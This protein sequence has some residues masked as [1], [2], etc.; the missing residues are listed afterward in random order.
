VTGYPAGHRVA[1]V[2]TKPAPVRHRPLRRLGAAGAGLLLAAGLLLGACSSSSSGASDS[3]SSGDTPQVVVPASATIVD[4]RTPQEYAE[5]HLEGAVNL[6]L[7]GGQLEAELSSLDP[8]ATY[9]VYCRTGNRSA[10]ATALMRDAG[11]TDVTDL[12][13]I[14]QAAAS[15]GIPVVS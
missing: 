3:G 15:T 1:T 5:G 9:V 6:D 4:V 2:E 7:S 12:G 13:G 8:T 11:F 10:T 14:D